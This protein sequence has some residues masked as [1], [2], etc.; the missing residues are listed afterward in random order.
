MA[1]G[2]GRA[3]RAAASPRWAIRPP[4]WPGGPG[5]WLAVGPQAIWTSPDG[6]SWTLSAT[7]GITPMLPGDQMWVLNSTADGFLAA[8]VADGRRGATQAV[9]WTSRDGL[10]WQRKTAAQLGLAGPGET[11]QS[12][13]Y[14][15]SRGEDTV[16]S[17]TV[18]PGQH[19]LLRCLAEH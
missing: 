3:G 8:G 4:G 5:G 11:V 14:I 13:S 15:T 17:G 1:A 19:E 10:T 7:H 9:I 16:I 2:P 6:L 18:T 12:I